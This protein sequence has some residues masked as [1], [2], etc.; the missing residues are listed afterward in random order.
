M[1]Y[2]D[3]EGIKALYIDR[4]SEFSKQ[5]MEL[6]KN[7]FPII[8]ITSEKEMSSSLK[9][10]LFNLVILGTLPED[11]DELDF[12]ELLT[13]SHSN[14]P[15]I[16]LDHHRN[17]NRVFR[18]LSS[19]SDNYILKDSDTALVKEIFIDFLL[20]MINTAKVEEEFKK[21]RTLHR[22][23]VEL[24]PYA[25][26]IWDADGYFVSGNRSYF[27]LFKIQPEHL[28]IL[29]D[30]PLFKNPIL[31]N[32]GAAEVFERIKHETCVPFGPMYY[33]SRNYSDEY[34][35]NPIYI[36]TVTLKLTNSQGEIENYV[37]MIE[38][39]TERV[40]TQDELRKTLE[41]LEDRVRIRTTELTDSNRQL[42]SEIERRISLERELT[43]RNRELQ[44]FAFRIGHDIKNKI[45]SF[46]RIGEI[47]KNNP[48][49]VEEA[50]KLLSENSS[51]LS[52]FI[53]QLLN[54]AKA[55]KV[56]SDV[57]PFKVEP[58]I[59]TV[60]SRLK[61]N[62]KDTELVI[63]DSF[64]TIHCDPI[65]MDQVF[66]NLIA[67]S[68]HHSQPENLPLRIEFSY[69]ICDDN[70]NI[71]YSDNGRGIDEEIKSKVFNMLFTTDPKNHYGFGLAITKKIIEAHN[72]KIAIDDA[73][74]NNGI[75]FIITL[76][77]T[78][79]DAK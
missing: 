16:H 23:L 15:V 21:E 4:N 52:H 64:P 45:I 41:E 5:F 25:I 37:V 50:V 60:F 14:L 10:S 69:K 56:I 29:R 62:D 68:F 59:R 18:I 74:D 26:T 40:A 70:V 75:K 9:Q 27:E 57:Q 1:K 43:L 11:I 28:P 8:L 42:F 73:V 72:G 35:D 77:L 6:Y 63:Q 34:P 33:N 53:E 78:Q 7:Y 51:R 17:E 61:P 79:A 31:V 38:D 48:G 46:D 66:Q 65:A 71:I 39:V 2:Q 24:N 19:I 32:A 13:T 36:N 54:L 3:T 44:D 12:F 55:G 22:K 47:L 49:R 67:N 58:L 20:E 30:I 76:P